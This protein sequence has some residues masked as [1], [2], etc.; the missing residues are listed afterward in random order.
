MQ[1]PTESSLNG[2]AIHTIALP[3]P[4]WRARDLPFGSGV[5]SLPQRGQCT[6]EMY[7]YR[8]TQPIEDTKPQVQVGLVERFEGHEDVVK[9]FVWRRG[10]EEGE[11]QMITL[12][13]DR[14]LRFWPIDQDMMQVRSRQLCL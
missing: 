3:Y 5:L 10:R 2:G 7:S 8:R 12:S 1:S 11:Y 14:T 6:L 4:V 9:E 13:K